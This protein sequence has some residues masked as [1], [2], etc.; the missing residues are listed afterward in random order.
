MKVWNVTEEQI[1]EAAQMAGVAIFA[2]WSGHGI[3]RDGRALNFRLGLGKERVAEGT[4]KENGRKKPYP[5][6][7]Q[8]RTANYG[9][10][11]SER[12]IASVCWHGHYAFMRYLLALSPEARIKSAFADYHG[13]DEFLRDAPETGYRNVGSLMYPLQMREACFCSDYGRD[14]MSE[15]DKAAE[16]LEPISRLRLKPLSVAT[17]RIGGES[18]QS[19]SYVMSQ[20][21]IGNYREDGSCRCDDESHSQMSAWGYTWNG[22]RWEA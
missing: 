13:L 11:N 19:A 17:E 9:F 2:D 21:M 7:W 22:S 12:R 14:D 15:I 10:G 16:E 5:L 6:I 18:Y 8:R 4:Y 20:S 1:R 3:D